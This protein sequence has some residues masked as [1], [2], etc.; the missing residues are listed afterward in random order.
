MKYY[1][2]MYFRG[3]KDSGSIYVKTNINLDDFIDEDDFLNKLIEAGL[4]NETDAE[5][6][7]EVDE[8]DKETYQDMV[9]HE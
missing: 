1:E 9:G 4:L 2:L 8:I 5:F 3:R 6:I 7:V